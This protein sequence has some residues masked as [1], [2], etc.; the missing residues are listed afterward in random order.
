MEHKDQYI[1]IFLQAKRDNE[2]IRA[3]NNGIIAA[4]NGIVKLQQEIMK[5]MSSNG[6]KF[7]NQCEQYKKMVQTNNTLRKVNSIL[8]AD[9]T[10]ER[11]IA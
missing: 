3:S 5:D 4:N 10:D 11:N 6:F 1:N 9:E 7:P 2:A 8:C